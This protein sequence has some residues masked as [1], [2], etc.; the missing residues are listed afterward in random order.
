MKSR[1][2]DQ[3][4]DELTEMAKAMTPLQRLKAFVEHSRL[5]V[6]IHLAGQRYRQTLRNKRNPQ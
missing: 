1:I 6:Q 2:A 4:R 5:L 3:L